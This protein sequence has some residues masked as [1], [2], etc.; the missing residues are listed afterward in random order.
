MALNAMANAAPVAL[1]GLMAPRPVTGEA[2]VDEAMVFATRRSRAAPPL[3]VLTEAPT[4]GDFKVQ[5]QALLEKEQNL[6]LIQSVGFALAF[7]AGVHLLYSG[8]C[9]GTTKE[10][11]ALFILAFGVDLTRDS[12]MAALK[13]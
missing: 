12:M 6:A 13:R 4:Q 11:A 10:M 3:A 2:P 5:R 9:V 7:I 8:D 1:Q